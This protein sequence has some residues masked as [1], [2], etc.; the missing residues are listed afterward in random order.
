VVSSLSRHA[1]CG[2]QV[3]VRSGARPTMQGAKRVCSLVFTVVCVRARLL[4]TACAENGLVDNL[5]RVH[6][7]S[8]S[9]QRFPLRPRPLPLHWPVFY[10]WCS[11]FPRIRAW[12]FSVWT[13][14]MEMDLRRN[15]Y[16]RYR[17]HLHSRTYSRSLSAKWTRRGLTSR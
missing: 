13:I 7:C 6:G 3:V 12:I 17:P 14:R 10:P 5:A 1:I 4:G 16:W 2:C 9:G 11:C 8:V 15:S